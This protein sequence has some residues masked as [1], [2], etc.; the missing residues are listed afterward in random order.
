M[1]DASSESNED[2]MSESNRGSLGWEIDFN[3]SAWKKDEDKG[4][5]S[6]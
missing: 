6:Y 3:S 2:E 5:K 4:D 1:D